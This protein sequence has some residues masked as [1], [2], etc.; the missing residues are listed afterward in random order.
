MKASYIYEGFEPYNWAIGLFLGL[1][2]PRIYI[3]IYVLALLG[4]GTKSDSASLCSS[5][6]TSEITCRYMT[7]YYE[8]LRYL[9]ST[10]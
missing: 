8:L 9:G 4:E 2:A 7:R 6:H 10:R 5:A 1:C 3:Y